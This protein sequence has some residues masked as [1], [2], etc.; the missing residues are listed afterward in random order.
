MSVEMVADKI[1]KIAPE[2]L[3]ELM[4]FIDF[5]LFRQN[6]ASAGSNISPPVRKEG[7]SR[8]HAGGLPGSFYMAPDFDDPLEDFAEYM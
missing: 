8:R 3:G 1:G 6:A 5:L 7:K 4:Q 2:H